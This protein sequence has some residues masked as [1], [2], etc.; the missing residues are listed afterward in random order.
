[1]HTGGTSSAAT[2]PTSAFSL[3]N[4]VYC[5]TS[6]F[7]NSTFTF[8]TCPVDATMPPLSTLSFQLSAIGATIGTLNVYQGDGAGTFNP[9]PIFTQTGAEPGQAQN[10]V[11]WTT[12]TVPLTIVNPQ[13]AF[14]FEYL[15]GT[16]F[17]G[18]LAIDDIVVN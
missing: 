5:E 10:G 7:T 17:T 11:E 6:G 3:P 14:R 2:G 8:E 4:Y 13:V 1:V 12:K 18:D 16:S 15:S 9:T